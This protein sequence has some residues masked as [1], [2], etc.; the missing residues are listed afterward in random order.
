V[1]IEITNV[2]WV[3]TTISVDFTK[4]GNIHLEYP[5]HLFIQTYPEMEEEAERQKMLL[6][7]YSREKP[8]DYIAAHERLRDTHT[9]AVH[10]IIKD[11]NIRSIL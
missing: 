10:E 11:S 2:R 5:F 4:D 7:E 9:R 8:P 1:S 6:P 3:K